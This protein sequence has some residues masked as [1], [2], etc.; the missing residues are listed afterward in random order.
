MSWLTN[1]QIVKKIESN[2]DAATR[3]AFRGVYSIDDLPAF[4]P[5]LPILLIVNTQTHNLPGEHWIAIFID[6]DK[7]GEVFDSLALPSSIILSR[8][9]NRFTRKWRTNVLCFQNP[10]SGMCGG[11]VIYFVLHRL[12][13]SNL[14]DIT[15]TFTRKFHMNDDYIANFHDALK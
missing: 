8:W 11:Y 15:R 14:D 3:K 5:R 9:M 6:K 13:A 7:R 12:S 2:A 4:I 10:L 1:H